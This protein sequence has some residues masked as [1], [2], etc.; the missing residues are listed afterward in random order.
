MFVYTKEVH[1]ETERIG[2]IRDNVDISLKIWLQITS[3]SVVPCQELVQKQITR[4]DQEIKHIK[5]L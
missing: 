2:W 5:A 3:A 4:N 1:G